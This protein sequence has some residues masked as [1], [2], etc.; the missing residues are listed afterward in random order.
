MTASLVT[1]SRSAS[2]MRGALVRI[3]QAASQIAAYYER[4]GPDQ[5]WGFADPTSW[6]CSPCCC[7][8][9]ATCPGGA[10]P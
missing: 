2:Q 8:H 10:G 9:H 7:P 5:P 1:T 4:F 3:A 6:K